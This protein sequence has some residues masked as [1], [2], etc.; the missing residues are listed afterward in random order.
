MNVLGK[1][2]GAVLLV[3]CSPWFAALADTAEVKINWE[4]ENRFRYFKRASDFREIAKVYATL[5]QTTP[6]PTALQLERALERATND[7]KFNGITG[8]DI[9]NGWA[10]SIFLHTCGRGPHHDHA[11]CELD[12]GDAYLNPRRANLILRLT[13]PA[14]G[15]CEW[16][17]DGAAVAAKPCSAE[18]TA[19]NVTYDQQHVLEV[20]TT[21]QGTISSNIVLKDA[22]ILSFGDSF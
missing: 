21:S 22:L 9:R 16:L 14:D 3:L 12:N 18:V 4:I 7:G 15:P 5:K 8:G 2:I 13:N 19:S 17:L 1:I 20:H 10:A 6:K 11:S